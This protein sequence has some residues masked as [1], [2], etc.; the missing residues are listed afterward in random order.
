MLS[1]IVSLLQWLFPTNLVVSQTELSI[2]PPVHNISEGA[3]RGL[4]VVHLTDFHFDYQH[5]PP[6][7]T[8]TLLDDIVKTNNSLNPDFVFLTGDFVDRT[9]SASE[10]LIERWLSKLKSKYGTYAVLGNHD[11]KDGKSGRD[12]IVSNL[13]KHNITVLNSEYRIVEVGDPPVKIEIS[14]IGDPTCKFRGFDDFRVGD[15]FSSK[16]SEIPRILLSHQPDAYW[17]MKDYKY[18]L[19]LSGHVHGGQIVLPWRTPVLYYVDL[20]RRWAPKQF[21]WLFK[22][23]LDATSDWRRTEGLHRVPNYGEETYLYLNRGVGTHYPFR[24]NC[25]AELALIQ[26]VPK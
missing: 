13:E 5:N 17:K 21:R 11:Y 3:K 22:L 2:L 15:T 18:H 9:A 4:R 20:I 14:G 25:P 23:P 6:K 12:L 24:W 16:D 7:I 10:E 1:L 8:S 26:L 19:Q